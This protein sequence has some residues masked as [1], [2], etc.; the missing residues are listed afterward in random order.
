MANGVAAG[1]VD[2]E[3]DGLNSL[4]AGLKEKAFAFGLSFEAVGFGGCPLLAGLVLTAA[5]RNTPRQTGSW[6]PVP[7]LC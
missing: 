7:Q 3:K 4:A 6:N 2:A 5:H 1:V